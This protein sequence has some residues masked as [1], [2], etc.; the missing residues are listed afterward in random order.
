MIFVD[1]SN[2]W[3]EA[4]KFAA[5]GKGRL[6]KLEDS[7]QDPRFRVDIGNL[8]NILSN[9]R[10]VTRSFLYGSRPPPNDKVWKSYERF[11]FDLK[12]Y[13]RAAS[14]KEKQVDNSMATDISRHATIL[15]T[16]AKMN[17]KDHPEYKEELDNMTFI[18]ISGDRDM[19]P[20]IRLALQCKI[21]VE[22]WAWE[23]GISREHKR[24][25][26]GN[27]Q[28]SYLDHIA[29]DSFFTNTRSTRKG[30]MIDGSKVIVL[31]EPDDKDADMD[32]LEAS[33]SDMLLGKC[34]LVF[35]I[36]R[37]QTGE[38]LF[39]EFPNIKSIENVILTVRELLKDRW[40]VVSWPEYASRFNKRAPVTI[41][42]GTL[43]RPLSESEH[44]GS[45]TI[46]EGPKPTQTQVKKEAKP[47]QP[48]AKPWTG[49]NMN[50]LRPAKVAV[51]N[52]E[53][54]PRSE[55]TFTKAT[56]E[57]GWNT[58]TSTNTKADHRRIM[59][60]GQACSRGLHCREGNNCGHRHSEEERKL[61][62]DFPHINFA[63]WKTKACNKP[64]CQEGRKCPYAHSEADAWCLK[65]YKTGHYTEACSFGAWR[66]G[67]N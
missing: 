49:W 60:Q 25:N 64:Y 26:D 4:Q 3:I 62:R 53:N 6:P 44:D 21:R 55:P 48:Q 19:L 11:N 43:F 58:V 8:V 37:S 35:Y 42:T 36:T 5:S 32:T 24:L 54:V 52:K 57:D 28:I 50:L 56:Q 16:K 12:I 9:G 59:R 63:M 41:E 13:D 20:P 45:P 33:A 15:E 51:A 66:R 61:F 18:V 7:D 31:C 65:C 46:E 40:T 27:L 10:K 67:Y 23:S 1:D 47:P 30:K 38:E 2:I 39:V 22:I 34:G 29:D 14:G 17:P